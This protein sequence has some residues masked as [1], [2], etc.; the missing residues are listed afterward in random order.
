[1]SYKSENR[2]AK[3]DVINDVLNRVN[4]DGDRNSNPEKGTL[5]Y[6]A[7]LQMTRD[8]LMRKHHDKMCQK[9]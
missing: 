7:Q 1:M 8:K 5:A 2:H 4:M 9:Q 6:K 3:L